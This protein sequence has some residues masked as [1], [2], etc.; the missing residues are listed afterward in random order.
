MSHAKIA[1]LL[2]DIQKDFT[3]AFPSLPDKALL[4]AHSA[5]LV[6]LVKALPE[7]APETPPLKRRKL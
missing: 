6:D 1:E 3:S 4:A 7:P 5:K 2:A